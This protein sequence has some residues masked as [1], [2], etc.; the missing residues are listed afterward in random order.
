MTSEPDENLGAVPDLI[1][2]QLDVDE[3]LDLVVHDERRP[4][5]TLA[6]GELV[7]VADELVGEFVET[8]IAQPQT[9][10]TYERACRRFVASLGPLAGAQDLTA[11]S[12]ARY[13]R[14]L[15][16]GRASSTVKKERAAINS[17]LR[18]FP[19]RFPRWFLRAVSNYPRQLERPPRRGVER[20]PRR[21]SGRR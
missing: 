6:R 10:R 18:W 13:H 19:R 11:A 15:V 7:G 14:E 5:P 2:G 1:R 17:F 16:K 21:S 8:L 12:V 4:S 3:V 20:R 9:Q